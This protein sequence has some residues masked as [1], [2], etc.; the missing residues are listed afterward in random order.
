MVI[1]IL[2][3]QLGCSD[4]D[5]TGRKQPPPVPAQATRD[6]VATP[7]TIVDGYH[8]LPGVSGQADGAGIAAADINGNGIVDMIMMA[9]DI[10]SPH[11]EFRYY[12]AYDLA[13]NGEPSYLGST[14]FVPGL[15]D[16]AQGAGIAL[17][18]IDKNG[19]L[20]LLLMHYD[21]GNGNNEFRYKVGWNIDGNAVAS[22]W[23]VTRYVPGDG[24]EAQGAGVVLLD[25]DGGGV[26]DLLLMSYN[27]PS[28]AN[29][30]RYKIGSN[31]SISGWTTNWGVT[32]SVAGVGAEADGAACGAIRYTS[33]HGANALFMAYD[34]APGNNT[35]RYRMGCNMVDSGELTCGWYPNFNPN[36]ITVDGVGSEGNGAGMTVADV[37]R[38][39][40][41]DV[42][43]MAYD[44]GSGGNTFRYR[45]G[46][47]VY[48]T[49]YPSTNDWR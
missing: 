5:L 3:T 7:N 48:Q 16:A 18:D 24:F 22:S 15:G 32:R 30:F 40:V 43:F 38:N 11:N 9:N 2:L 4:Q 28:G 20:D 17:G 46:F 37:D 29:D 42:I 49:A 23:S 21:I 39:G 12:V 25:F 31:L 36:Y 44:A 14:V 47:N 19:V 45:V 6:A 33:G 26:L 10:G 35:F 27:N 1:A 34:D 41:P 8:L 13:T